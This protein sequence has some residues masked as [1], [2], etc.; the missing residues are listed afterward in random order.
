MIE[1]LE[2]DYVVFARSR[3]LSERRVI[4]VYALRNALIPVL[5]AGGLILGYMLTGTVLIEV[6]FALPGLGSLVVEAIQN[7]DIPVLQALVML[8]A[9]MVVLVN[10]AVDLLYEAVDP[11]IR[12]D[13]V[14]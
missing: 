5:T 14:A 10:L 6:T 4:S 3:G 9:F 7:K 8:I 11:R 2:Q 12:L 1:T 13:S